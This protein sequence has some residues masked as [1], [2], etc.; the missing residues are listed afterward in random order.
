MRVV[1]DTN[2]VVAGV[3]AEGLCREIVEIHLP[4]HTAVLSHQL[5]DELV[6]KLR[7]KF[8]LGLDELPL[9]H[10]YRRYALWVEATALEQPACRDPDDDWVLST[11]MAGEAEAIVTGD[12][13]LLDLRSYRGIA[14]L[15]PRAFLERIS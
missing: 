3:V 2:V 7:E 4:Q 9:L 13:D 8:D 6:A 10:L 5:W 11:A 15:S 1:F 14:I 12:A